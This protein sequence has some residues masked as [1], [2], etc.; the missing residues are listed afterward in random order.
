MRALKKSLCLFPV[1]LSALVLCVTVSAFPGQDKASDELAKQYAAYLGE[2]IFDMSADGGGDVPIKFFI[3]EGA[4]WAVGT[5][6]EELKFAPVEGEADAFKAVDEFFGD[7][8]ATFLKDEEDK[9]TLCHLVIKA[10]E[11]D[12]KGKKKV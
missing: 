1:I 2:Y 4:L 5:D 12:A 8:L 10:M 7:V 9:Y 6:L 3:K 11:I